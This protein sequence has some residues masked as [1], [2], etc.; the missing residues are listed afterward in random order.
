M[1]PN[2]LGVRQRVDQLFPFA[3][4]R[5]VLGVRVRKPQNPTSSEQWDGRVGAGFSGQKGAPRTR[6]GAQNKSKE[7]TQIFQVQEGLTFFDHP[8]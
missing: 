7:L 3:G 6:A 2:V 4:N 8:F 1:C 5:N